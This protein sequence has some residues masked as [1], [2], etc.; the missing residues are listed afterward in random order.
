MPPGA[1]ASDRERVQD[2]TPERPMASPPATEPELRPV[3]RH[4][5][6]VPD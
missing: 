1:L 2:N 4:E 6:Y 5:R 3:E